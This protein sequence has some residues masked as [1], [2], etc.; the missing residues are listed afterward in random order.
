MLNIAFYSP[1]MQSGKSTCAD[2]LVNNYNYEKVALA[3]SLKR[4]I[5]LLLQDLGFSSEDIQEMLY[6]SKKEYILTEL[7]NKST[8]QL[9]QLLGT[10]FGRNLIT[11]N[12]WLKTTQR[13]ISNIMLNGSGRVVVE[14]LRLLN[15][16]DYFKN[17]DFKIVKII[18]PDNTLKSQHSSES[19][20]E[21][22]NFDYTII[23]NSSLSNLYKAVDNM[24]ITFKEDQLKLLNSLV[25]L[26][27][28][29][30]LLE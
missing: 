2:Y 25:K 8:R 16:A 3:S 20:L 12:I 10:E 17:K 26:K 14:D 6:G 19:A 23:N 9:M 7:G 24:L 1:I 22:Y 28:E 13:E 4:M 11:P 30:G 29:Y 21:N 18:R 15:E 27:Q 5:Q